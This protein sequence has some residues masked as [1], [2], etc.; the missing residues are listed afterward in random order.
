[1]KIL[2]LIILT[3]FFIGV[4]CKHGYPIIRAGRDKGCKVSCVINNQY[5]DTECKQL[6]GRRGYCYFW[7]LACFC[8]YLPDYVPTWS[9]A[10]NKCKA[11]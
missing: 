3:A 8:E 1:M 5:C 4:H 7:R 2:F 9:R 10:T 6:K 11:K